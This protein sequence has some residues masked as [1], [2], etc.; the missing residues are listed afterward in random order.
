[1]GVCVD[2]WH[3]QHHPEALYSGTGANPPLPMPLMP[4]LGVP[5]APPGAGSTETLLPQLVSSSAPCPLRHLLMCWMA[6]PGAPRT[7]ALLHVPRCLWQHSPRPPLRS[8]AH[9][10]RCP[11]RSARSSTAGKPRNG[12][13][14]VRASGGT[15]CLLAL[16]QWLLSG[17]AAHSQ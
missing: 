2:R 1:M 13:L 4:A 10:E 16:T 6:C 11:R 14:I 12:L 15:C 9:K 3:R 5:V 7:G 17:K 8:P